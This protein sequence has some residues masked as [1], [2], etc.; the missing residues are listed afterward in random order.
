M[1]HIIEILT[2]LSPIWIYI[3]VAGV[4]FTEN[5]FPP[6]PSDLVVVFAGSLIG[7]GR[8]DFA[9]ML[10]MTTA[11]STAGFMTMYKVGE[12][13]GHSILEKKKIKFLPLENVR[14]VETWFQIYG[15]WL[16]I[17]NRFLSG[18]RAVISFFAGMSDL[19]FVKTSLLS[20]FSALLWNFILLIAGQKLGEHWERIGL[21]LET[22]S[23]SVTALVIFVALVL[24]VRFYYKRKTKTQP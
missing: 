3:V 12:W 19:S 2:Q 5:V 16:I 1:E 22:Y 15:Y 14:T 21:Y 6:F 20:F 4:A 9:A 18:T 24:I 23:R 8:V 13:F 17:A 11:G 10:L 7:L